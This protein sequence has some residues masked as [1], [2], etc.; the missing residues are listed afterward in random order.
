MWLSFIRV[1]KLICPR[2]NGIARYMNQMLAKV[3][4]P[5][6]TP[7][8]S[9]FDQSIWIYI[10]LNAHLEINF[11]ICQTTYCV[12]ITICSGPIGFVEASAIVSVALVVSSEFIH[13][14]MTCLVASTFWSTHTH[15]HK[16][17]LNANALPALG[18]HDRLSFSFYLSHWH[19]NLILCL[20]LIPLA[21]KLAVAVVE[22]I[23]WPNIRLAFVWSVSSLEL[24]IVWVGRICTYPEYIIYWHFIFIVCWNVLMYKSKYHLGRDMLVVYGS[25]TKLCKVCRQSNSWN[26]KTVSFFFLE[27]I[28]N[29]ISIYYKFYR[30]SCWMRQWRARCFR[31]NHGVAHIERKTL[32]LCWWAN[33]MFVSKPQIWT[34]N[35]LN[36][37][38]LFLNE[39][40][41]FSHIKTCLSNP[42][43]RI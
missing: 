15:S 26:I 12:C 18:Y 43:M 14:W 40:V 4:N 41:C 21:H 10:C 13:I 6:I 36:T 7:N 1:T 37:D 5:T 27:N 20:F 17:K 11:H 38:L 28:L 25:S 32:L 31:Q 24:V 42:A 35:G 2:S 30:L 29:Y 16:S 22:L 23:H 34:P 8:R 39:W 3:T 19:C 9:R 33:L